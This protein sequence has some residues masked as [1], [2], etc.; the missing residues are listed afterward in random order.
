MI[1]ARELKGMLAPKKTDVEKKSW[2]IIEISF[3]I[4][5]ETIRIY[6]SDLVYK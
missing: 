2:Y 6:S 5:F 4:N 3:I 1:E